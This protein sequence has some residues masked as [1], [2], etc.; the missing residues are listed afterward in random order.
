[1]KLLVSRKKYQ[2]IKT[3]LIIGIVGIVILAILNI[4]TALFICLV[5]FT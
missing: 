5:N 4:L 3:Y 1:M 2:T